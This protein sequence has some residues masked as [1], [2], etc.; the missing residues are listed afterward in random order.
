M[1]RRVAF[2]LLAIAV[3]VAMTG[4][5]QAPNRLGA[6]QKALAEA[7]RSLPAAEG[8][9]V[10]DR[11]KDFRIDLDALIAQQLVLSPALDFRIQREVEDRLKPVPIVNNGL[12]PVFCSGVFSLSGLEFTRVSHPVRACPFRGPYRDRRGKQHHVAGYRLRGARERDR[13]ELS[14]RSRDCGTDWERLAL[15]SRDSNRFCGRRSASWKCR[16][17]DH[18][19]RLASTLRGL[20]VAVLT[21]ERSS[22]DRS[23]VLP[24]PLPI[25]NARFVQDGEP[26]LVGVVGYPDLPRATQPLFR[27]LRD[28]T[29][30][31][32]MYSPGAVLSVET[33]GGVDVLFTLQTRCRG[34]LDH[35]SLVAAN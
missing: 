30:S 22:V 29:S 8:K 1:K 35:P 5:Q 13:H 3:S 18:R 11:L 23:Q 6:E 34:A 20:D 33:L 27:Q 32:K 9:A 15:A 19:H 17:S 25:A 26:T 21:V 2:N 28:R 7:I 24:P 14:C 31:A 12:Q 4:A 10:E 16:V